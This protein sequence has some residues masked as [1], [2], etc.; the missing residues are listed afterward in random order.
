MCLSV[1]AGVL[2]LEMEATSALPATKA[3]CV[4]LQAMLATQ[5][6]STDKQKPILRFFIVFISTMFLNQV[7]L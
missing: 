7:F 5:S 3:I 1:T 6:C 2:S 4:A